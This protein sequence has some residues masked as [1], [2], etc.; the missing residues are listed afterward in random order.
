MHLLLPDNPENITI[1]T[2][3]L[4]TMN[5]MI[6]IIIEIAMITV[7]DPVRHPFPAAVLVHKIDIN[8]NIRNPPFV[9]FPCFFPS[10]LINGEQIWISIH[11]FLFTFP[12]TVFL[13]LLLIET[14]FVLFVNKLIRYQFI[15]KIEITSMMIQIKNQSMIKYLHHRILRIKKIEIQRLFPISSMILIPLKRKSWINIIDKPFVM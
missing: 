2:P 6:E 8:Y 1:N 13:F 12:M 7:I 15:I 3:I 14:F 9:Y 11:K 4:I 5:H 10:S